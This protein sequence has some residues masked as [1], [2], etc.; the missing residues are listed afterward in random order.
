MS[1]KFFSKEWIEQLVNLI[2]HDSFFAEYIKELNY[3]IKFSVEDR[4]VP[5]LEIVIDSGHISVYSPPQSESFDFEVSAPIEV[6]KSIAEG[7]MSPRFALITRKIKFKGSLVEAMKH[8]HVMERLIS[9]VSQIP[10]DWE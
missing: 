4:D 6:W 3:R 5:C 8:E 2:L 1:Y 10:T 9:K 7:R